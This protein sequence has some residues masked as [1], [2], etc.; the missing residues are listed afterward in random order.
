MQRG[1]LRCE[2]RLRATNQLTLP[3]EIVR[4][5]GL[6]PGDR[7]IID[8]TDEQP[9]QARLRLLRRSYAGI[10]SGMW[11]SE[12]DALEYVRNERASRERPE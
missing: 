10:L 8:I 4:R 12:E 1:T 5:L 9:N 7:L 2:T 3:A 11:G 6:S